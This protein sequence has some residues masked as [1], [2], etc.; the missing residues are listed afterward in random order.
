ITNIK[1][2]SD[3]FATSNLVQEATVLGNIISTDEWAEK[4]LAC[5]EDQINRTIS[6]L[7]R[8]KMDIL[9]KISSHSNPKNKS[10]PAMHSFRSYGRV[11]V[12]K[13]SNIFVGAP[14]YIRHHRL[15][16]PKARGGLGMVDI[17]L[18]WR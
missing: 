9:D 16:V 3:R 6:S 4:N 14:K 2:I 8:H 1:R 12:E 7:K 5:M 18:H 13:E 15:F 17:E 10:C 11:R